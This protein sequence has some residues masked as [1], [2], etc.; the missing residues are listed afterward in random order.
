M[1]SSQYG[2]R[3]EMI[4]TVIDVFDGRFLF[5]VSDF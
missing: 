4:S 2:R 5:E 3:D 1:M